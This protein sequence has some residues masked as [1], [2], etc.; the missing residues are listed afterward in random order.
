M[1]PWRRRF[2]VNGIVLLSWLPD[3]R[4]LCILGRCRNL[5]ADR[6][7]HLFGCQTGG[8]K[9][10]KGRMTHMWFIGLDLV[11]GITSHLMKLESKKLVCSY[12]LSLEFHF[13]NIFFTSGF[14]ILHLVLFINT[15]NSS[16]NFLNLKLFWFFQF[17]SG[18]FWYNCNEKNSDS[19][20]TNGW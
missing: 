1:L 18:S 5:E 15:S 7:L 10:K 6:L 8:S 9:K 4:A 17:S 2:N 12:L 19:D 16:K 11:Y 13:R 20:S 3:W 14:V